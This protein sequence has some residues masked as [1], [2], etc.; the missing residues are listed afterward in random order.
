MA[1][2][3][4]DTWKLIHIE[5]G[6]VA[7]TLAGL[8]S[9]QWAAASLCGGWSIH[10]AA[11]HVVAG[12]EQ[13]P[14]RFFG[15]LASN[16]FRFNVMIDRDARALA[17]RPATE[18]IERLRATTSTTNH[19]PAP[20]ITMLGEVVVHS[21]DI[22]RPLGIIDKP[23]PEAVVACLDMFWS[24]GFPVG[25]KRRVAG[26]RFRATDLDWTHGAGAE[27]TGPG[28]S[29]LMAMTGRRAGLED[30]AGP[31]LATLSARLT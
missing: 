29:L 10:I 18:I 5:R 14:G 24:A 23:A 7:D 27:V 22:R 30:L 2:N 26:L 1:K 25:G 11:A 9:D 21:E 28:M 6:A 12:A 3:D 17:A 13:T 8:N 4:A 20:V 16:A 19:P 31:G 15:H